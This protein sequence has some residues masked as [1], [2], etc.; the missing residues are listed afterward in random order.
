MAAHAQ[1]VHDVLGE[2]SQHLGHGLFPIDAERL[3]KGFDG[4]F[5]GNP[6]SAAPPRAFVRLNRSET[7]KTVAQR[8]FEDVADSRESIHAGRPTVDRVQIGCAEGSMSWR[9]VADEGGK[10]L[11]QPVLS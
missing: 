2:V 4:R 1:P 10:A 3:Q 6:A 5:P 9:A 7:A 8:A 11:V